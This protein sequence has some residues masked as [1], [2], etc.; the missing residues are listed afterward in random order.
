MNLR[1]KKKRELKKLKPKPY[2]IYG[3]FNFDTKTLI[4]VDLDLERLT[5]DYE[6]SEYDPDKY[7]IVSF[8][9]MIT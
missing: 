7:D 6:L 5:F 2:R 8:D 3:I 9:I 1:E 4:Q